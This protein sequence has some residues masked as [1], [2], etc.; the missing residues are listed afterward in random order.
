MLQKIYIYLIIFILFALHVGSL[1]YMRINSIDEIKLYS[2]LESTINKALDVGVVEEFNN[3]VFN[4]YEII[5]NNIE[6]FLNLFFPLINIK[7]LNDMI[8][9]YI[10]NENLPSIIKKTNINFAKVILQDPIIKQLYGYLVF[11]SNDNIVKY[12]NTMIYAKFIALDS[13]KK[14]VV[15]SLPNGDKLISNIP[16][17]A[18]IEDIKSKILANREMIINNKG[19]NTNNPINNSMIQSA[20]NS[21]SNTGGG[22]TVTQDKNKVAEN[23]SSSDILASSN[24]FNTIQSNMQSD[25]SGNGNVSTSSNNNVSTSS[26]NSR[27][28]YITTSS[29]SQL[30]SGGSSQIDKQMQIMSESGCNGDVCSTSINMIGN[31]LLYNLTKYD[32][33]N[34][35]DNDKINNIKISI[36]NN[37][38]LIILYIYFIIVA[39]LMTAMKMDININSDIIKDYK[40]TFNP[41]DK[42]YNNL[43]DGVFKLAMYYNKTT[44]LSTDDFIKKIK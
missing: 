21:S 40:T 18:K 12:A 42:N 35:T 20:D 38:D 26:N 15:N 34:K 1:I 37:S 28:N 6:D 32:T 29:N 30:A 17:D 8:K 22:L 39:K 4:S 43:S 25:V 2:N 41:N 31:E 16:K 7:D 44:F 13:N 33:F 24:V 19:I 11:S 3:I 9:K 14:I 36:Y 10:P 5:N 27:S 23:I